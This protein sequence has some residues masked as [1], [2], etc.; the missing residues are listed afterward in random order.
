L[1]VTSRALECYDEASRAG[2]GKGDITGIPVRWMNKP[3]K[4]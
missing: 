3:G 2:L 1:P 4:T